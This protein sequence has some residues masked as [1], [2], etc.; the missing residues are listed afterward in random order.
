MRLLLGASA[1]TLETL[2]LYPT[3]LGG[4]ELPLNGV[5]VLNGS[6]IVWYNSLRD[7]DLSQNKS[8]RALHIATWS[9]DD[10]LRLHSS[11]TATSLLTY[12]LSTITSP[13]F[14]EVVIFYRDYDAR[15]SYSPLPGRA[16]LTLPYR[17]K[18][19]DERAEDALLHHR[20]FGAFRTMHKVRDFRLVSWTVGRVW[21]THS[22]QWR[23]P[24]LR[25]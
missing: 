1:K 14:S 13:V 5:Q 8:L 11:D 22:R 9:L 2:W 19:E 6:L 7:F 23:F 24:S 18:I 16:P 20:R 4:K 15:S 17:D 12:A 21:G 3:D 25:K 10:A